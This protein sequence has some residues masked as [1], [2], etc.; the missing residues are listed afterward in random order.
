MQ[1]HTSPHQSAGAVNW[2]TGTVGRLV[3]AVFVPVVTFLILWRVFI[4]LR[5]SDAPKGVIAVVAIIWGVG[6]VAALY[7]IANWLVEQMSDTWKIML[8]PFVFVGPALAILGWY[9]FLPTLRSLYLSFLD[10]NSEQF[11]WFRNYA[12]A[13]TD[14]AM[15]ESFRNNLLWLIFGTGLS[16]G[17]GL[18]IA[19]LADRSRFE[20]AA[21][22]IIFMP[23][24]ISLVGAGVIWKFIYAA[25][26]ISQDQIG[27]LNALLVWLGAK[28]V[29]WL[30]IPFW[31]NFFLI[32]IMVWMQTGYAMVLEGAA[33][34]QVPESILEA[35][36]IDGANEVQIFFHVIIP[37][38]SGTIMMVSTT[39]LIATLKIFDI[40]YSMTGGLGGTE[41]I[42][43]QQYKQMF[44]Y[45]DYGRGSAIAMVL[46]V[47]TIPIMWYNLRQ[48][49]KQETFK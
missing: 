43:S 16:V 29:G 20:T 40:V 24:A 1:E 46:L 49:G 6:G 5:D 48:F 17:F 45:F 11:V 26:P 7:T 21:K 19:I 35:A 31:N 2:F 10:K 8:R 36:R 34:K 27:I 12:Y 47:A 23:M 28:P 18:L 32:A 44:K 42:A 30:Q 37:S 4:F 14:G 25:K 38:I 22:T 15:L 33:I 3:A 39:I 9:L 13:F 41:V